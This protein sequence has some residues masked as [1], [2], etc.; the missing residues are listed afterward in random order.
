MS[1]EVT[2]E[3]E[4]RQVGVVL[5]DQFELLDVFGPVEM[6]GKVKSKFQ[7]DMI[8]SAQG[9]V[10]SVQGPDVFADKSFD[11]VSKLDIVLVPGGMGTRIEVKNQELLGWLTK[12]CVDAEFVISVCTGSA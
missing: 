3:E 5:F 2:K 6:L 9:R 11:D 1:F 12:I 7:I 10:T 4:L 8:A